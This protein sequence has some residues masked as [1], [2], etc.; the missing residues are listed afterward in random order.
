V[1]SWLV[2]QDPDATLWGTQR[3]ERV[4]CLLKSRAFEAV[5]RSQLLSGWHALENNAWRWT[6]RKFTIA[7]ASPGTLTLRCTVPESL[8]PPVRLQWAGDQ[9]V[10]HAAG[11]YPLAIRVGAGVLE[12][13]VDQCLAPDSTDAR[14]RALIVHSVEVS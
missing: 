7:V 6:A 13:E 10:F 8:T 2:A 1:Y 9:T 3:D 14:E 4:F 5:Q 12:F 11:D